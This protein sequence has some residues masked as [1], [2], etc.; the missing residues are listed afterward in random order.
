M[1]PGSVEL[2]RAAGDTWTAALRLTAEPEAGSRLARVVRLEQTPAGARVH[3][4]DPAVA[5]DVPADAVA[6]LGLTAGA[7]V[8]LR[9]RPADVRLLRIGQ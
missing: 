9:A 5:V 2:R 8:R 7:P 4:A 1:R 6:A 3:T